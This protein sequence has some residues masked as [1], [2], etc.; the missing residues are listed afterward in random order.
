LS[1]T[2]ERERAKLELSGKAF[3]EHG[4]EKALGGPAPAPGR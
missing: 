1:T 3:E 4:L 2:T